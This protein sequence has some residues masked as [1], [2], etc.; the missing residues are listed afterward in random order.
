MVKKPFL[1]VPHSTEIAYECFATTSI[2]QRHS[3]TAR[4]YNGKVCGLQLQLL[5]VHI[6]LL[7]EMPSKHESQLTESSFPYEQAHTNCKH[8]KAEEEAE[9]VACNAIVSLV[10]LKPLSYLQEKQSIPFTSHTSCPIP[11]ALLR[12]PPQTFV[13]V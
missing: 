1:S 4:V 3:L 5:F 7:K 11:V 2:K 13:T 6:D 9:Q 10:A 12:I 8:E